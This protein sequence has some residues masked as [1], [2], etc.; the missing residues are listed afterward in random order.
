M[1]IHKAGLKALPTLYLLLLSQF[2]SI[3][4]KKEYLGINVK[5]YFV[6]NF[7]KSFAKIIFSTVT[8]AFSTSE[9]ES[10]VLTIYKSFFAKKH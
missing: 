10:I 6:R 3:S 5:C 9:V 2:L 7:L 4:F 8:K 1:Q